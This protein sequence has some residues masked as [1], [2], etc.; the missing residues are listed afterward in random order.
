LRKLE[1][2][3]EVKMHKKKKTNRHLITDEHELQEIARDA[4]FDP[5]ELFDEHGDIKD[6]ANLPEHLHQRISNCTVRLKRSGK[7]DE[8]GWP[9]IET[10]VEVKLNNKLK[11]LDRLAR[12]LGLY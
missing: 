8:D 1:R 6:I 7:Y 5:G 11:A 3:A 9:I 12:H 10:S 2:A 4:F